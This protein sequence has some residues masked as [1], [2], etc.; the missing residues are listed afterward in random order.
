[1]NPSMPSGAVFNLGEWEAIAAL[2]VR[3]S[4]W[5]LYK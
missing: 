2:C 4:L 3:H 1:M 5:L